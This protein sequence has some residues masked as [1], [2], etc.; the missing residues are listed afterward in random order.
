MIF[1]AGLM[2]IL[3]LSWLAEAVF[4]AL[5]QFTDFDQS[6]QKLIRYFLESGYALRPAGYLLTFWGLLTGAGFL[7]SHFRF[8]KVY[9]ISISVITSLL[10]LWPMTKV[11][12]FYYMRLELDFDLALYGLTELRSLVFATAPGALSFDLTIPL[13]F[14]VFTVLIALWAY[15]FHRKLNPKLTKGRFILRPV[16]TSV[17]AVLFISGPVLA[18]IAPAKDNQRIAKPLDESPR[19]A[20][21][22]SPYLTAEQLELKVHPSQNHF[23]KRFGFNLPSDTNIVIIILESAREAF[24]DLDRSEYFNPQLP[25]TIKATHFF[26]PVPHSSNSHYSM[27]TGNH[28]A[29]DFEKLYADLRPNVT[30][31]LLLQNKGYKNYYVYTDH[32]AFESEIIMLRKLNMEIIE[33]NDFAKRKNP[34]TGEP[35]KSF[36]F[37]LDD[38]ALVHE[39]A[40]ILDKNEQPFTIT[41]VM[42]NS[43]YP[44]INPEPEKFN[45]FNNNSTKG[46]H[47]NGVDYGLH[48]ADLI[49]KEFE[50][51]DMADNTLFVLMSD[52]GE[53]F[54]ERGYHGHSFSIYNEEVRIPLVFRHKQ[55]HR[56]WQENPL[57][58][59]AMID[60]FPTI[61]DMLGMNYP[62]P[63]HGRS[64]FDPD[65]KLHLPLWVWR[66]D[67]FR[68]FISGETKWIYD[69]LGKVVYKLN[70]YDQVQRTWT[71]NQFDGHTDAFIES[72]QNLDL[73][74][75]PGQVGAAGE[76][77]GPRLLMGPFAFGAS[78]KGG[79]GRLITDCDMLPAHIQCAPASPPEGE[80]IEYRGNP[81]RP[82]PF[83]NA[84]GEEIMIPCRL[85]IGP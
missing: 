6:Q 16:L 37:G 52:H 17:A 20:E 73:G 31:P 23:A 61:F 75:A 62:E 4:F 10:T 7:F 68:G 39:T 29:R 38:I 77:L 85:C 51:R 55:F 56:I 15:L 2:F 72:L 9:I 44:Y 48:V 14:F 71:A 19:P 1:A 70:L 8:I 34:E 47:R 65:Y 81:E 24:V 13:S 5:Y 45:R 46:R 40:H 49:V 50:K 53:S 60:I 36:K 3:A 27:Y 25:E 66:V 33:K 76:M 22:D 12:V 28:S 59:G 58:A 30:M 74:I 67:D 35:Y 84:Q 41:A 21:G 63:T 43:H 78:F 26:T 42:T 54:G 18:T 83:R 80:E 32:T 79:G 82:V 69:D 57:P 11:I 64:M